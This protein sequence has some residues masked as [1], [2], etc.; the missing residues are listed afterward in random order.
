MRRI[1]TII[2]TIIAILI[3]LFSVY[4]DTSIPPA[5]KL[6][7]YP[8]HLIRRGEINLNFGNVSFSYAGQ[9]AVFYIAGY[10]LTQNWSADSSF[11]TV[12]VMMKLSQ[13]L[14]WPFTN[15]SVWLG[16]IGVAAN[17]VPIGLNLEGNSKMFNGTAL[18][19]DFSSLSSNSYTGQINIVLSA[20]FY[21]ILYSSIYHFSVDEGTMHLSTTLILS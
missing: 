1:I 11:G 5:T 18:S 9:H 14:T 10:T 15:T 19:Y 3:I 7:S 4:S 12:V 6:S 13:N 21:F 16:Q 8:A 17:G 20:H 2:L